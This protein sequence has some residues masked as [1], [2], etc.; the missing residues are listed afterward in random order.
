[1]SDAMTIFIASKGNKSATFRVFS[2]VRDRRPTKQVDQSGPEDP[3]DLVTVPDPRLL[4]KFDYLS[5]DPYGPGGK[6]V[7]D[8]MAWP[9]LVVK[10]IRSYTEDQVAQA[11]ADLGAGLIGKT[12]MERDDLVAIKCFDNANG[13]TSTIE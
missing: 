13:T 1:M 7:R 9:D 10:A 8:K 6:W 11:I 12:D 2:T 4:L 3:V 5:K